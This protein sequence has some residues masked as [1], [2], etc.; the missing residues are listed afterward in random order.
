MAD[1]EVQIEQ[2]GQTEPEQFIERP[3]RPPLRNPQ[4]TIS[5][6]RL[7]ELIEQRNQAEASASATHSR[8]NDLSRAIS[9]AEAEVQSA[10]TRAAQAVATLAQLSRAIS[11]ALERAVAARQKLD[12]VTRLSSEIDRDPMDRRA[13]ERAAAELS[14]RTIELEDAHRVADA[15][16]AAADATLASLVARRDE[17]TAA[18]MVVNNQI[19]AA[20]AEARSADEALAT[21]TQQIDV[22]L[23]GGLQ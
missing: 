18:L 1:L 14:A 10:V 12:E 13:L 3:N 22:Y 19:P 6:N 5:K 15:A 16:S 20:E 9:Q 11:A 21:I 23:S 17:L 8:L 2:H 7:D 4:W